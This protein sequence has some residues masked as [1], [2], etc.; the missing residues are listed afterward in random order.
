PIVDDGLWGFIDANGGI[1]IE[2]QFKDVDQFSEGLAA[3]KS[4]W[5]GRWGYV[6]TGGDVAIEPVFDAA[7]RFYE[8]RAV[9]IVDGNRGFIN[10]DGEYILRPL[11]DNARRFSEGRAFILTGSSW[12][13]IDQNGEFINQNSYKQVNS[14]H[15][16]LAS[17][18]GF[19]N[20]YEMSGYL[21]KEGEIAFLMA[22]DVG[23]HIENIGF[24]NGRAIVSRL[25]PLSLSRFLD[26]RWDKVYGAIDQS[27]QVVVPIKYDYI[28]LHS[29]CIAVVQRNGRYGAIDLDGNVVIPLRYSYL[30]EFHEGLA[31]AQK[32]EGEKYGYMNLEGKFVIEPLQDIDYPFQGSYQL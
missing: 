28:S 30:G 31:V 19:N 15:E 24:S 29:E 21:N 18:V 32:H 7:S 23:V 3:F 14:F 2:P 26:F 20:N 9:V 13:M 1:K 5:D 10:T 25:A 4:P 8:G 17:F 22:D 12:R 16:E 11:Y 27:G 6:N